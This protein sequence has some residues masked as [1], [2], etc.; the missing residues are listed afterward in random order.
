VCGWGSTSE[1]TKNIRHSLPKIIEEYKIETIN[2]AGCGDLFWIQLIPALFD[3]DYVGYDI[4]ER[5]TWKDL[6]EAGW[7][8]EIADITKDTLRTCDL[9]ICRDVFIHLP[10]HLILDAL[11]KIRLTSKYLLATNYLL[12]EQ[13]KPVDNFNRHASANLKHSKLD[14][15]NRPFNLGD[16]L[17]VIPEN[18]NYKSTSLWRLE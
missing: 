9:T 17:V 5:S 2:D 11:D 12:D 4:Y 8:L 13:E 3:F 16:P 10:N 18:Y 6:R 7:D 14:L 1:S 15:R